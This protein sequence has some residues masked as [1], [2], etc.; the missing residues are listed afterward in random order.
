MP[1]SWIKCPKCGYPHFIKKREDTVL[2]MFPAY[3]KGCKQEI[4]VNL[5]PKSHK[6]V[7]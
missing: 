3:C 6:A 7:V 2:K 5:E 4:L 1:T